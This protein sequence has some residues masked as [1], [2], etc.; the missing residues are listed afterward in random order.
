MNIFT[1]TNTETLD[2][3]YPIPTQFKFIFKLRLTLSFR[4]IPRNNPA[5]DIDVKTLHVTRFLKFGNDIIMY[6]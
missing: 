2:N 5:V 6:P 3:G 4:K 1:P